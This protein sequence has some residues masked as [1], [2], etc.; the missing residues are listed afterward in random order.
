MSATVCFVYDGRLRYV[1]VP[2]ANHAQVTDDGLVLRTS[3]YSTQVGLFSDW[4]HVTIHPN[5]DANG[6]FAKRVY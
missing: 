5:R 3:A 1:D 4:H 2:Q 6:R